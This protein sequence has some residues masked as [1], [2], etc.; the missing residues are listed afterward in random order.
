MDDWEIIDDKTKDNISVDEDKADEDKADKILQSSI[1]CIE[2]TH[3]IKENPKSL[4]F[5]FYKYC[6][7][8]ITKYKDIDWD[9]NSGSI[10]YTI[11]N[12]TYSTSILY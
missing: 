8:I 4:C 1:Y 12:S 10:I 5:L 9:V 7:H 3:R 6:Q 11:G 2:N